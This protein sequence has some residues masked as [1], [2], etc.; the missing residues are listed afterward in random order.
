MEYHYGYKN[1]VKRLRQAGFKVKYKLPKYSHNIEAGDSNWLNICKKIGHMMENNP[2][3]SIII[4]AYNRREF[5]LDAFNS[6]AFF[7]I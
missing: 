5:L 3:I 2:Y 7:L 4:T 6:S 1:L